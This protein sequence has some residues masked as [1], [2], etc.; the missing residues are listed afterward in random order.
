MDI[1]PLI[2]SLPGARHSVALMGC[3][4]DKKVRR[5]HGLTLQYSTTSIVRLAAPRP[6]LVRQ[7]IG[8]R[9]GVWPTSLADP[10]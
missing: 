2:S 8:E 1:V 3:L 6:Y 10:I 5:D 4:D 7:S 9:R